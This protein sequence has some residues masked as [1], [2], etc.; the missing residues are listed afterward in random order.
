MGKKRGLKF[1]WEFM[2][3]PVIIFA[4]YTLLNLVFPLTN[5]IGTVFASILS[6]A[7]T[8]FVF[9]FV[10][11]KISRRE[12]KKE[13]IHYGKAGAWSGAV[14]GL[15]S[16]VLGIL[17]FYLLPANFTQAI[18]NA[19]NAGASA[20]TVKTFM[21][22]G[23]FI[24]LIITPIIYGLIGALLTWISKFIFERNPKEKADKDWIKSKPKS[25]KKK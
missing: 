23:L 8:I 4:L 3:T 16:A 17:S 21:Q 18:Q 15:I 11:F 9:G 1:Y 20:A 7:V 10:G 24:S 25:G 6:F 14:M 12:T 2:D 22:I 19:V 5:Y 13:E